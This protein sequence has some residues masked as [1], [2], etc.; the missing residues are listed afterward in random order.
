MNY[1]GKDQWI[2]GYFIYLVRTLDIA[3]YITAGMFGVGSYLVLMHLKVPL[4]QRLAAALLIAYVFLVMSVTVLSRGHLIQ[5]NT[6]LKPFWSYAA[7]IYGKNKYSILTEIVLNILMLIP[8]GFLLPLLVER[9][10][11]LYGFLCSLCIEVFQLVTKRGYFEIDDL[12][13]NT[14]GAV[15]GYGIY[16]LL[17]W[18]AGKKK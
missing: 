7:L 1:S 11:V 18:A 3:Y 9:H 14:L 4:K 10:T 5:N 16:R 6:L 15:I 12:I 2:M 13:H 17:E 8:I